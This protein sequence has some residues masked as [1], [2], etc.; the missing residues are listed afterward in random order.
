M[1]LVDAG[2]RI[3]HANAAGYAMLAEENV[4]RAVSGRIAAHD[5]KAWQELRDIFDAASQGDTALGMRGIA[6]PLVARDG[7]NYVAHLLPLTSGARSRTGSTFAAVAVL[8][9]QKATLATPAM[10][11]VI[12]KTYRLT[13]TELRILLAVAEIG[14][15]P[16]VA[17]AF[18]I[19]ETTVKFHLKS[20]FEKT[21]ARRQA[22]LV[23]LLAGF[24]NPLAG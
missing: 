4:L 21:G 19:A 18:G 6:L 5:G 9:V 3:V 12:A 15:T 22:D 1:F 2:G 24:T 8:L 10:P 14:G 20:L 23:K 11:E 13:P 7:G 16:E 17:E